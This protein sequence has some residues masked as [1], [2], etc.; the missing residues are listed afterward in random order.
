MSATGNNPVAR[1]L[2]AGMTLLELLVVI[3]IMAIATAGISLSLRD[4]SEAHLE[5]EGVRL[6][7]LL[8]AGR[9][10]SR[11]SGAQVRWHAAEDGFHFEGLAT[12]ALPERWLEAGIFVQ[13]PAVLMLGPEPIIGPQQVTLKTIAQPGRSLIVAT[14]GLRPFAVQSVAPS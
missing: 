10:V 5:R 12:G 14:D 2:G 9:A 13:L 6:A 1:R 3:A 8:E 4:S 7:A 11:A